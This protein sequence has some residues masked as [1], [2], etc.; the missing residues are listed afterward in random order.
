MTVPPTAP[1]YDVADTTPA[2]RPIGVPTARSSGDSAAAWLEH[3][4]RAVGGAALVAV[5]AIGAAFAW[6]AS[7]QASAER[8]D[9]AL[10]EAEARFAQ[11]DPGAA[12]ALQQVSG[13]Y[14]DTP[15]GA[16]ARLLLAQSYYDQQKYADGLRVLGSGSVPA[17]WREATE[18]LRAVGEEGAGRPKAA[19][20]VFE[21]LATDAGPDARAALLGDAARAYEGAGDLANARR[22]WQ[23]L[24]DTGARGVADEA[25]VRVGEL[26]ARA[27]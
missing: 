27:R 6:R 13:R 14:G 18:R 24:V 15:A 8:A 11:G 22:V 2:P 23:T 17:D 4:G 10:Y 26:N 16:H 19:A 3:N 25:R 7:S 1:S 5:V 9:R 12:Q 20:V 21:R